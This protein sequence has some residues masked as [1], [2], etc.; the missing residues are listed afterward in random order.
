MADYP[1]AAKTFTAKVDDEDVAQAGDINDLQ[2]ELRAV[3]DFLGTL[4]KT[5]TLSLNT[6][7]SKYR[8]SMPITIAAGG[9]T[10]S[11]PAQEMVIDE[12]I[13]QN[14]STI[15]RDLSEDITA[16]VNTEYYVFA[17]DD[18]DGTFSLEFRSASTSVSG[19][20]WIGTIRTTIDDATIA[21]VVEDKDNHTAGG[22]TKILRQTASA[23]ANIDFTGLDNTY[24]TYMVVLEDVI[25]A[26]DGQRVVMQVSTNT[27]W[28]TGTDYEWANNEGSATATVTGAGQNGVTSMRVT[29]ITCGTVAGEDLQGFLLI[30]NLG[31]TSK[32]WFV[33]NTIGRDSNA[34]A[35]G[36]QGG[37]RYKTAEANDGIRFT[38]T[39]GNITSGVFTL[40]GLRR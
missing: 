16:A 30:H 13:V 5:Q 26:S 27:S 1:T 31:S 23:D 14:T 21:F 2:T 15:T 40:F 20:R 6:L 18:S 29:A 17:V 33:A 7:L 10:V 32:T 22:W 8:K 35:M 39:S 4:S 19:K 9:D 24:D 3:I 12:R 37:G 28:N 25:L 38:T 11:C 34:N 36:S